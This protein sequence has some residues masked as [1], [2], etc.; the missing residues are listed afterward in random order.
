MLA[1]IGTEKKINK[2][3]FIKIAN[4][5]T[6]TI[7]EIFVSDNIQRRCFRKRIFKSNAC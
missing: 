2:P 5:N 6:S 1:D 7:I 4:T 3:I